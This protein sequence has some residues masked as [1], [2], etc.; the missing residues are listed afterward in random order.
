MTDSS[1]TSVPT[2]SIEALTELL[3]QA[4]EQQAS[5][6]RRVEELRR[7]RDRGEERLASVLEGTKAGSWEW[8]VKTG[9]TV[10]NE[11]WAEIVG[12]TLAELAPISIQT[13]LDLAHPEDLEESGRRLARVFARED[14][15]YDFECRMRHRDGSWVWVHDRGIVIEWAADGSPVRMA[16]SHTDITD[17]KRIEL[18]LREDEE[19]YRAIFDKSRAVKLLVD[20]E[21]GQL[22]DV[23]PAGCSFYGHPR[24]RMRE[25][26]IADLNTQSPEEIR[27]EMDR[28]LHER[29]G[30]FEFR[31][32]LANGELRDVEVYPSPVRIGG[33]DLLNSIVHDVTD[34][35]RAEEARH[36]LERQLQL[37]AKAESLARMAGAVAHRFNNQLQVMLGN[38]ELTRLAL[39]DDD[40]AVSLLGSSVR[41]T[42]EAAQLCDLMLTYLGQKPGRPEP[43]DVSDFCRD[44]LERFRETLPPGAVIEFDDSAGACFVTADPQQLTTVI[45]HLLTNA[46][47]SRADGAVRVRLRVSCG[48]AEAMPER[49]RLPLDWRPT[50]RRYACVAVE[51]DGDG[52]AP[53]DIE[54]LFDPFYSTKFTG[55]G[56]GLSVVLG[57]V[58]THGGAVVVDSTPGRGSAFRVYLPAKG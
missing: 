28:A 14:A 13:W 58:R 23:N 31:H 53:G 8:N 47:E 33:R 20:P 1:G 9:E 6:E 15:H 12:W 41:A 7:A 11:R 22:V 32:R 52:I 17:R 43:L 38:L 29:K 35:R 4:R 55:R 56:M 42:Q 2:G 3:R 30:Y 44:G 45:G 57:L 18:Q 46:V 51:D 40:P 19:L 50:E 36:E 5:L 37:A 54:K 39:R 25:M 16:G 49:N 24:E 21:S 48:P 34:R 27:L 26:N 10:F